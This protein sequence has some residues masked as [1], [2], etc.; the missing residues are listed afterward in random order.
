MA[1]KVCSRLAAV[2]RIRPRAAAC[3]SPSS[4]AGFTVEHDRQNLRFT[5]A[6]SSGAG[7][8]DCA[9][10][11][12]RFTGEGEVDLLS[13]FVPEAFRGRGVAALLTQA[14]LDF[15]V[16]EKLR[17]RVSCWYIK[18]YLEEHRDHGSGHLL[19]S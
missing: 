16:E 12:Y 11:L 15:L 18:A 17:A 19:V 7:S 13:T 3:G 1:L 14:A 5:A 2:G 9:V 10:L 8:P 4:G 6:P